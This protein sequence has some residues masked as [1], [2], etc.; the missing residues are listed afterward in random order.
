MSEK[1]MWNWLNGKMGK[2]RCSWQGMRFENCCNKGIPDAVVS[3]VHY[4]T[5]YTT[6][7]ELKDWS[8]PKKHPLSREQMNFIKSFGGAVLI[9][10]SDKSMVICKGGLAPLLSSDVKYAVSS[11]VLVPIFPFS[12]LQLILAMVPQ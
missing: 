3:F 1:T 8:G 9:K 10:A 12:P 7:L 5:K 11:G 2:A 4:D 6:F